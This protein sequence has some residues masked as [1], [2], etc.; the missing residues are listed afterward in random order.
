MRRKRHFKR[1]IFILAIL[2]IT[3]LIL[4][5][6]NLNFF[7]SLKKKDIK[8]IQI[9]DKCSILLNSIIHNIKDDSGCQN[10]CKSE[11]LS[12][13]MEFYNSEFILD[14]KSCNTC[15]CSCR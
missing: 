7:D 4:T 13:D 6:I 3:L 11:C 2:L 5:L 10:L 9:T 12:R 15:N 14:E 8:I 1:I